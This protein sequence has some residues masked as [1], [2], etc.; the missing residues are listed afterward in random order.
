MKQEEEA[1]KK[2]AQPVNEDELAGMTGGT[3]GLSGFA[4]YSEFCPHCF[5]S[6]HKNMYEAHV[7][8]CPKNPKNKK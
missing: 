8:Q 1:E 7:E 2:G 6:I 5:S 3:D 4:L